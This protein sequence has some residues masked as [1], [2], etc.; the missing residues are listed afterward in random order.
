MSIFLSSFVLEALDA[1][2]ETHLRYS[3]SN[4][5][6]TLSDITGALLASGP[7]MRLYIELVKLIV[8]L[9]AIPA[10][11]ATAQRSLKTYLRMYNWSRKARQ[12]HVPINIHEKHTDEI[13][14]C[15]VA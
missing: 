15:A 12:H 13:D 3:R 5:A 11:S 7:A 14:L 8:L 10:T 1:I 9:L 6:E 2:V 4:T